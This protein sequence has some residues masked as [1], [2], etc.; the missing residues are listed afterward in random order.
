[1]N[2]LADAL[3]IAQNVVVPKPQHAIA[4]LVQISRPRGVASY[5]AGMIMLTAVNFDDQLVAVARKVG[6][7]RTDGRL[8]TEM[9]TVERQT[10]QI[11]PQFTLS[12]RHIAA[13]TARP[14]YP[15]IALTR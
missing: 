6:K 10:A 9:T 11:A 14:G 2:C 15:T 8:S 7:E 12:I 1:L 3:D 5:L 13:Q 4:M